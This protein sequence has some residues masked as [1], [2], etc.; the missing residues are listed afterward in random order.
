LNSLLQLRYG[1]GWEIPANWMESGRPDKP[2]QPKQPVR[3]VLDGVFD[4][5]HHGHV[6]LLKRAKSIY[7]QVVVGLHGDEDTRRN[8]RLPVVPYEARRE[9]VQSCVYVDVVIDNFPYRNISDVLLNSFDI[10]YLL[11]GAETLV[12]AYYTGLAESE[13]LHTLRET[14]GISTTAIIENAVTRRC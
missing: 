1:P 11:H 10:D 13:R 12:P 2:L 14:P 4:V 7:D 6:R 3:V 5:F 9:I 8:K